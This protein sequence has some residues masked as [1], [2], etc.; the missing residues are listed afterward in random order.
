M[1]LNSEDVFTANDEVIREFDGLLGDCAVG[2]DLFLCTASVG[3]T[4]SKIETVQFLA[5]E[6]NDRSVVVAES[7]TVIAK[8]E[9]VF[10]DSEFFS[11]IGRDGFTCGVVAEVDLRDEFR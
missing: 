5:V 2:S 7:D 9:E 3:D 11:E 1:E 10:R 8:T 4:V 6:V